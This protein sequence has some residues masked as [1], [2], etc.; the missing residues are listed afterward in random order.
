M[1][2]K[3]IGLCNTGK[4]FTAVNNGKVPVGRAMAQPRVNIASSSAESSASPYSSVRVQRESKELDNTNITANGRLGTAQMKV[5]GSAE[6]L[7]VHEIDQMV[8]F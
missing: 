7:N 2:P 1:L 5:H 8:I 4:H 6:E 3:L